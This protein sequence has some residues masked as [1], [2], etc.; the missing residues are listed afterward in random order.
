M[1]QSI[2]INRGRSEFTQRLRIGRGE[3]PVLMRVKAAG[4]H[5]G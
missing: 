5:A 2:S 4:K 1:P 3:S